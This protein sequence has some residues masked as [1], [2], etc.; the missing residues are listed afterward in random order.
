MVFSSLPFLCVF[1]PAVFLAALVVRATPAQNVLLMVASLLFYAYGEPVLVLL[2]VLMSLGAYGFGLALGKGPARRRKLLCAVATT[3]ALGALGAFKYA[4]WLLGAV[5][6]AFD[7]AMTVEALA[8]PVGISFYTFQAISYVVDVYRKD[9][10]PQRNLV[11][12]VLYISFFPQ[13]IAGPIIRYHD[14]DAQLA[15]RAITLEGVVA[16]LRRFVVG[17]AKKVLVA[18]VLAVAV[19]AIFGADPAQVGGA[20][21]WVAALAYVLQIYFDFSGYSDMAIGMARMFGFAYKENFDYPYASTSIQEF[22]RRWHISLSTWFR[23]CL[24]IPL[25]G[26]RKGKRRKYLNLLIT[27]LASGLWHGASWNFVVWGGINGI[28]QIAG[29]V[30]RPA[31]EKTWAALGLGRWKRLRGAVQVAVTFVLIDFAWLFFRAPSLLTAL[32]ILRHALTGGAAGAVSLGLAGPELRVMLLSIVV[33]IGV[34]LAGTRV[35]IPAKI[36]ALPLP[37]RW[38]IYLAG[39]YAVLIFGM[40]GPGFSESQFIYFQF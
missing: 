10:P 1:L 31:R 8:L 4:G 36:M 14:V 2:M 37:V 9:V 23:D 26:N 25:G 12:L 21:A 20:A 35:Q 30:S 24:Y 16:G 40:Y 29:E 28:Y 19:D 6:E 11:R 18:D 39:I 5:G 3:A 22:W 34:D 7:L 32:D 15:H 17:L 33:L 27:F 38:I 13:L